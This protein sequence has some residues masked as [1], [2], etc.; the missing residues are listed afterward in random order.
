MS[1]TENGETKVAQIISSCLFPGEGSDLDKME[2]LQVEYAEGPM[3]SAASKKGDVPF[4]KRV[5][6]EALG[7]VVH[8]LWD[9]PPMPWEPHLQ[10]KRQFR[11]L[12]QKGG[13]DKP[14]VCE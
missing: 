7:K 14:S 10:H 12:C 9:N 11:D 3:V 8:M 1:W 6:E 4:P 5:S 2:T 13:L